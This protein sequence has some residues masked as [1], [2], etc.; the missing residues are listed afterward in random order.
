MSKIFRK[1]NDTMAITLPGPT[2]KLLN[3]LSSGY[4]RLVSQ[5]LVIVLMVLVGFAAAYYFLAQGI[6]DYQKFN[7]P[8]DEVDRT[9]NGSQGLLPIVAIEDLSAIVESSPE[10]WVSELARYSKLRELSANEVLFAKIGLETLQNPVTI[11][12]MP[13]RLIIPSLDLFVDI[14]PVGYWEINFEGSIYRQWDTVD[15]YATAWHDSSARIGVPGNT[16]IS[17]HHNVH[18]EVF[19]DLNTLTNGDIIQ[20]KT[21]GNKLVTYRVA[22][23][24]VLEE[25]YQPVEVRME[26]AQW[27]QHS[28]DER[29]TLVTCWPN[30][31]NSHR[32]V[33]VAVPVEG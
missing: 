5:K 18:G 2:A 20:V 1:D 29:L 31:D 32:V 14:R 30:D 3:N 16:V 12:L 28:S 17:G 27:I 8:F 24:L 6:A 19:K 22:R 23:T 9:A 26:N 4:K 13:D 33:V 10:T 15:E 7:S 11:G 21:A 25:K